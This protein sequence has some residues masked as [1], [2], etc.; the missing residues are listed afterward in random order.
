[1]RIFAGERIKTYEEPMMKLLMQRTVTLLLC[2]W[3]TAAFA[4]EAKS[5]DSLVR[6][7]VAAFNARDIDA[8]LAKVTDDIVWMNVSGKAVSVESEGK[9]ALRKGMTAYFKSLPSAR[10]ELIWVQSSPGRVAA[11]EKAS[12]EGKSGPRSQVSIA[13]YEFHEGLIKRVHYFPSEK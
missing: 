9:E 6:D 11:L 1:M 4:Q 13:V 12:W 3:A 10:S 2:A 8:M 7:H 5:N